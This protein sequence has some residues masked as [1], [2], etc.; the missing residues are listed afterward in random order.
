MTLGILAG[1]GRYPVLLGERLQSLG[2][3]TAIAGLRGQASRGLFPPESPYIDVLLGAFRKAADFFH[4]HNATRIVFAGGVDRRWALLHTLP[5]R[6]GIRM[7]GHALFRGDDRLLRAA[8]HVFLELGIEVADPSPH[9]HDWF[10]ETGLLAGPPLSTQQKKD[11]CVARRAATIWGAKDRGQAAVVHRGQVLG[12]ET[13]FG[14]DA[15][16]ARRG[17]KGAVLVKMVKP[18]QDRRFDLPAVGE[19]TILRARS[20]GIRAV[21]VEAGGVLLLDKSRVFEACNLAEISLVGLPPGS[22]PME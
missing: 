22:Q 9:I 21:G 19:Q 15:L 3:A 18:G 7:I 20:K 12:R 14:T 5:D 17:R 4:T 6:E 16:I 10:G 13:V 8:A 2:I 1:N 11:L